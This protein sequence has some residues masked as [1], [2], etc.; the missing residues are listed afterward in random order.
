MTL[1]N[2]NQNQIRFRAGFNERNKAGLGLVKSFRKGLVK[3][4]VAT[5]LQRQN[6]N[7]LEL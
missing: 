7:F 4:N 6:Y 3:T 2:Q 5:G 1:R